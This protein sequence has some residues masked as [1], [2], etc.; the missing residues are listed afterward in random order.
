MY[1]VTE[2]DS[3]LDLKFKALADKNRRKI[4]ITRKMGAD[5]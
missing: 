2:K 4:S 3:F 1:R 5:S